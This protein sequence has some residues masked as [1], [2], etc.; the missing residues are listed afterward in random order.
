MKTQLALQICIFNTL[1][2]ASGSMMSLSFVE[3]Y[4]DLYRLKDPL[5]VL[6]PDILDEF[7]LRL[8]NSSFDI[9]GCICYTQSRLRTSATANIY[10]T[11]RNFSSQFQ[12][13]FWTLSVSSIILMRI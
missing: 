5:F 3:D 2:V 6:T 8:Q 10:L 4:M 11:L 9:I 12:I 1:F 7:F 13:I